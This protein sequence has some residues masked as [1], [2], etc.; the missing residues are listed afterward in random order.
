MSTSNR[1]ALYDNA[2]FLL[3][4]LVVIGHFI[5]PFTGGGGQSAAY[6]S[7]YLFIYS[8]H[9][10]LFIFVSGQFHKNSNVL[11]KIFSFFC[12]GMSQKIVFS[13]LDVIVNKNSPSFNLTG[14]WMPPWY[15]FALAAFIT[16]SYILRNIDK[17]FVLLMSIILALFVGYDSS[18]GDFLYL[19]RIIVFYPFYLMGEL[20]ERDKILKICTNKILKIVALVII[21]AWGCLCIFKLDVLYTLR[22]LF[23]G[24][25]PYS[26][27]VYAVSGIIYRMVCYLISTIVGLCVM[28]LVPNV[29]IPLL[30]R[31]GSRTMQVYFWHWP[32]GMILLQTGISQYIC[33]S[34]TTKIMWILLAVLVGF[35]L[36]FKC[37]GFFTDKIIYYSREQR[38]NC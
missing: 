26:A 19:S 3:I 25:N 4:I 35:V 28:I 9:M 30:T 5:D 37:F 11:S 34:A 14:D 31:F 2:K 21:V 38:E 13:A 6:Q 8:F 17:R 23:T 18:V 33:T 1:V 12:I 24:R 20:V 36:S 29:K 27:S 15:M 7:I 10:P 22:P 16:I 32:I